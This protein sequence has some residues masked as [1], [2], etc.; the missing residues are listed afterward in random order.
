MHLQ[1]LKLKEKINPVLE[2]LLIPSMAKNSLCNIYIYQIIPLIWVFPSC[3]AVK[4]LPVLQ[5]P[6]VLSLDWEDALKEGMAIHS[7]IL[8]WRIPW[9]EEP[10]KR[11]LA[12][13]RT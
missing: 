8:A 9:T 7:S 5:E 10:G 13:Y 2:I 6:H 4:N 11:S 12:S 1:S 3:S